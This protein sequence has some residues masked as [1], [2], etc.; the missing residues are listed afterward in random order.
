LL[1]QAGWTDEQIET[2]WPELMKE[3][4]SVYRNSF[5]KGSVKLLPGVGELLEALEKRGINLG[6]ITGN[7]ESVAKT[8]LGDVGIWHYFSVGGFGNDPHATRADL[9][10]VAIYKAGFTK[11]INDVHV[12]GDTPR[13][14]AAAQ[15]A[16][17]KHTVG[18]AN[19]YKSVQELIDAGAE[20][21]LED[22][23][24]TGATLAKL[25]L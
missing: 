6:L 14:I 9:V 7:I 24:D 22:F 1:E 25:G 18:V 8:K 17:I 13:D 16:G 11:A 23:R 15:D 21:A 19:G 3:I 10:T 2:A 4:D 5:K 20:V 12:I